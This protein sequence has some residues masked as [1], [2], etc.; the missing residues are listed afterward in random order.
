MKIT[1]TFLVW[2]SLC[3]NAFGAF[4]FALD[5]DLGPNSGLQRPRLPVTFWLTSSGTSTVNI[6]GPVGRELFFNNDDDYSVTVNV[7]SSIG[8][9]SILL[10][11]REKL[12]E[13]FP[14]FATVNVIASG[15]WRLYT[16]SGRAQ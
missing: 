7:I 2:L 15:N 1:V 12:D 13:R 6:T 4:N 5:R 11:S 3:T 14:E 9:M 8:T 16:R 10:L